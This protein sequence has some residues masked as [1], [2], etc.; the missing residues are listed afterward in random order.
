ML[1]PDQRAPQRQAHNEG[2]RAVDGIENPNEISAFVNTAEF[3]ANDA[4]VWELARYNVAHGCFGA[5][6]G[7]RYGVECAPALVI[8]RRML[9]KMS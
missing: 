9:A 4:M 5:F 2:A 7:S 3:F 8:G 1:Q 6:I